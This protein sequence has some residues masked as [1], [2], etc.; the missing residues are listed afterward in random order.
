M[1]ACGLL[2]VLQDKRQDVCHLPGSHRLLEQILLRGPEP[3][4]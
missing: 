4:R 2:I 1:I 3:V